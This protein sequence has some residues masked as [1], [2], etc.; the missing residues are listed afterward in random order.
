MAADKLALDELALDCP[1]TPVVLGQDFGDHALL[2]DDV[3]LYPRPCVGGALQPRLA[4]PAP[5][6]G[7]SP[8]NEMLWVRS[9]GQTIV[10]GNLYGKS[11]TGSFTLKNDL[12]VLHRSC[13]CLF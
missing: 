3:V 11:C 6:H 4:G 7:L 2:A 13:R 8:S 12:S 1:R 10:T 9:P 5:L